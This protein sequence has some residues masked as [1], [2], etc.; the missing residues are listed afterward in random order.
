MAAEPI[1]SVIIPAKNEARRIRSCLDAIFS[2]EFP[3]PF[4]VIVIDSGSSDG[5]VELLSQYDIRLHQIPPEEFGHGRTRNLGALL[6]RGANLVFLNADA[7]PTSRDW[8]G[9]LVG[10]LEPDDVAGV[11]GR[12]MAGADGY[13]MEHFFLDYWYGPRRRIQQMEHGR[14]DLDAVFFSTVNCA[15]KR[16]LWDRFP[17]SET[18]V[19]T[20]DQYW[21]R[22]VIEEGYK[23][24]YAPEAAVWHS[25]NYTLTK[26]FRRFFDSGWSS[27]ASYLPHG[28][29]STLELVRRTLDYPA[30]EAAYLVRRRQW[31]WL[32]YA[33]LYD[34]VKM[35]GVLA[36][37]SHRFL[38]ERAK[39]AMSA[40]YRSI[41][42]SGDEQPSATRP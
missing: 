18:I 26:A 1:A 34:G 35:A 24:V 22:K 28:R 27:E 19:M 17:F 39:S 5:T 23:L 32:L 36:G 15:L 4:E 13:P 38:P 20:E 8:L 21:S 10:E 40:N 37:R 14:A 41:R 12:Q 9:H 33:P 11:Y 3:G 31:R 30:R 29:G 6:A 2:Q 42:R 25:H 16:S 7:T